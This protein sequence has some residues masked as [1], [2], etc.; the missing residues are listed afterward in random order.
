MPIVS[1]G[2]G[3]R[4]RQPGVG[5]L[6]PGQYIVD[7]FPVLTAGPT[8]HTSL[9]DWDFTIVDV[10]ATRGTQNAFATVFHSWRRCAMSWARSSSLPPSSTW[11]SEGSARR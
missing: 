1:R 2:F 10:H 7:D 3:G 4:R 8:P 5:L 6:P 9:D 11:R